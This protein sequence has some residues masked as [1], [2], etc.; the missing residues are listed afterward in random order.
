MTC[1]TPQLQKI[2]QATTPVQDEEWPT[3]VCEHS[4]NHP[5]ALITLRRPILIPMC[6][7]AVRCGA[8]VAPRS[9][10]PSFEEAQQHTPL[11]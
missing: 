6:C 3:W 9:S 11:G 5:M 1:G 4:G 8:Q 7:A 10:S 2:A